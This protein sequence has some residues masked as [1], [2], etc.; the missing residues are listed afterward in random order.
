MFVIDATM[1]MVRLGNL[2][3][4]TKEVKD[5]YKNVFMQNPCPILFKIK[6][7][8]ENECNAFAISL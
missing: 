3:S 4:I 2:N 6:A 7:L 5:T 1:N 8:N